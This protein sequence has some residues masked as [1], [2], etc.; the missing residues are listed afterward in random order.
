MPKSVIRRESRMERRL[1][2]ESESTTTDDE[3]T[4]SDSSCADDDQ[5]EFFQAGPKKLVE[6]RISFLELA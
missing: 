3:M 5:K 4:S 2:R 6:E 1:S